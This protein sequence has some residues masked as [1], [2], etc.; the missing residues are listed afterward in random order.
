MWPLYFI[1][2]GERL[3]KG[4]DNRL[5]DAIDGFVQVFGGSSDLLL[6]STVFFVIFTGIYN[7]AR[8]AIS[9]NIGSTTAAVMDNVRI[10]L[11]WAFFLVPFGEY[12]CRVQGEF[13]YTATIGLAMLMLGIAL[14]NDIIIMPTVRKLFRRT[15]VI[16]NI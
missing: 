3:G 16:I 5:E 12:L 13:H 8:I 6:V 1:K 15:K 7:F 10:L 9:Q 2:V 11:V 14:Y 4:P